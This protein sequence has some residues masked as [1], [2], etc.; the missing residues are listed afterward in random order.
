MG[1]EGL[2]AFQEKCEKVF[3]GESYPNVFPMVG[4]EPR[5]EDWDDSGFVKDKE[6]NFIGLAKDF[7]LGTNNL[8]MDIIPNFKWWGWDNET[9]CECWTNPNAQGN[10]IAKFLS[11]IS[12]CNSLSISLVCVKAEGIPIP[13]AYPT[14]KSPTIHS[15]YKITVA[16]AVKG[17]EP[18]PGIWGKRSHCEAHTGLSY[19]EVIPFISGEPL[20]NSIPYEALLYNTAGTLIGTL[21]QIWDQ[22][23]N[24]GAMNY[25]LGALVHY[26][27]PGGY[28]RCLEWT[29]SE[30]YSYG[31]V[32]NPSKLW[33]LYGS[34]CIV[35]NYLMCLVPYPE[36]TGSPTSNPT[37][38]PSSP[39]TFPTHQPS[40]SPSHSPTHQ[41]SPSPT[42]ST[43]TLSPD[44][45]SDT[46]EI[47]LHPT[48]NINILNLPNMRTKCE[49]VTGKPYP[50]SFPFVRGEL[51]FDS[52]PNDTIIREIG[53]LND[54][55]NDK[56]NKS[57]ALELL[58][59]SEYGFGYAMMNCYDWT[60]DI[61]IEIRGFDHI[62]SRIRPSQSVKQ[63]STFMRCSSSTQII[64]A[65]YEN[66]R[67][68]PIT[69]IYLYPL[70]KSGMVSVED[71]EMVKPTIL[72]SGDTILFRYGSSVPNA[73]VFKSISGEIVAYDL[74]TILHRDFSTF[75][76]PY[77]FYWGKECASC[78]DWHGMNNTQLGLGGCHHLHQNIFK[79]DTSHYFVCA[80]IT[81][82]P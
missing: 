44:H 61:S 8:N 30:V 12:N 10:V 76:G 54:F 3:E 63:I 50:Q 64:C 80:T 49:A 6:G 70:Y 41:P 78:D 74:E 1:N 62:V 19:P 5:M 60:V 47:S 7:R 43:P 57:A 46:M 24:V 81:D 59:S 48:G 28:D 82:T 75:L 17:A 32:S 65:Q 31:G 21:S 68:L 20:I 34:S 23:Y 18:T 51:E 11:S 27:A 37:N 35:S 13:T 26:W 2:E 39:P 73:A 16:P 52:L 33:Y 36:W 15:V 58:G 56:Y 67:S 53:T 9:N 38:S 4:C 22:A 25:Y 29:S 55:L 69:T 40:K 66:A 77:C 42:V 14:T 72:P 71:C 79:C 45:V